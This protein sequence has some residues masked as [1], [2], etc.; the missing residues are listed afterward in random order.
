MR[1]SGK[2][3]SANERREFV[4]ENDS[5]RV[6]YKFNC[7]DAPINVEVLNK[8][9][10]PIYVDWSRSALIINDKAISYVPTS[11][12]VSGSI[13]TNSTSLTRP[14]GS[15]RHTT[16]YGDFNGSVGVPSEMDFIPP[17]AYKSKTPLG[18]TNVFYPDARKKAKNRQIANGV[19]FSTMVVA[20]EYADSSSP[21]Q[22]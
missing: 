15:Y 21:L 11:V 6:K 19:G 22:F 5:V 3:I 4:M 13:T 8:M 10:K 2:N 16:S 9:D 20:R 18:V 14:V 1:V 17:G 12:P 7:Q